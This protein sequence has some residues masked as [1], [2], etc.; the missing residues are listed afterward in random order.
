MN[1]NFM[2]L[3]LETGD[4]VYINKY[5]VSAVAPAISRYNQTDNAHTDI[6]LNNGKVVVV[7]EYYAEVVGALMLDTITNSITK[8]S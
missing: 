5:H 7:R 3:T 2:E 1:K 8:G 6:C 4:K